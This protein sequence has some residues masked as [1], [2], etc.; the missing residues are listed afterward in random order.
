MTEAVGTW[1]QGDNRPAARPMPAAVRLRQAGEL[2]VTVNDMVPGRYYHLRI[3]GQM[4]L[5]GRYE[6]TGD[7][8]LPSGE[9]VPALAL[10][11]IHLEGQAFTDI[12]RSEWTV[13]L[14]EVL[15]VAEADFQD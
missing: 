2:I 11:D 8:E 3:H 13:P 9:W 10:R 5:L 6:G 14:R 15:A 12:K 4:L 7:V 1:R